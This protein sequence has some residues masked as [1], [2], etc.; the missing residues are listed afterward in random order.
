MDEQPCRFVVAEWF[1]VVVEEC[2]EGNLHTVNFD[3]MHG[4][5]TLVTGSW[6]S[7]TE[8]PQCGEE[9]CKTRCRLF[10]ER[11]FQW[12]KDLKECELCKQ[13]REA[14][15]IVLSTTTEELEPRL[16][17]ARLI[18]PY[19]RPRYYAAQNRARLFAR[20]KNSQLLWAQCDDFPI[21]GQGVLT[22]N[23]LQLSQRRRQW[24]R[25]SDDKT[26]G[27]MGFMPLAKDLP[28]S[29]TRHLDK[30][31]R[32]LK[33]TQGTVEGWTLHPDDARRVQNSREPDIVL[34]HLP[35]KMYVKTRGGDAMPQHLDLPAQVFAVNYV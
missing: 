6:L 33:H 1:R 9:Q 27:V 26:G 13:Y 35:Y 24:L 11:T 34:E 25:R 12:E 10:T 29:F 17:A 32:I 18:T 16:A 8:L 14:R 30:H 7:S 31:R 3:F 28:V 20:T 22:L 4:N 2:R 23:S 21:E 5:E 15:H 19:N